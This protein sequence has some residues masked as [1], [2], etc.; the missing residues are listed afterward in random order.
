MNNLWKSYASHAFAVRDEDRLARV[1]VDFIEN[2]NG[3]C[4]APSDV[5]WKGSD[6]AIFS[7]CNGDYLKVKFHKNGNVIV[8]EKHTDGSWRFLALIED[9]SIQVETQED[10]LKVIHPCPFDED[11][12]NYSFYQVEGAVK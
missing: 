1:V 9:E 11:G 5:S 12:R 7:N 3:N 6:T 4:N 8:D 10:L 2:L